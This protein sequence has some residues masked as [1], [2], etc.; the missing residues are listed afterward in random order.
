MVVE[1]PAGRLSQGRDGVPIGEGKSGPANIMTDLKGARRNIIEASKLALTD[2][3][4]STGETEECSAVVGLAG[5][6]IQ[7]YADLIAPVLPF[8]MCKIE[9]DARIALHG[10]LE[11]SDGA[12]A[13]VGTGSVFIA[14]TNRKIRSIG[15]WGFAVGDLCS[16]ARLGRT[17]LQEVLLAYDNIHDGS[18]L[19][20]TIMASFKDN[21]MHWLNPRRCQNPAGLEYM[22]RCYLSLK[23]KTT[24]LQKS[25]WQARARS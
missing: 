20:R 7:K 18:E 1:P 3:G 12:V 10:A 21:P 16:G 4:F 23:N 11:E 15:G 6:N 22:L 9:T 8:G 25:L 2:A 14:Q 19:T 5:A 13:I 24:Q 17:L